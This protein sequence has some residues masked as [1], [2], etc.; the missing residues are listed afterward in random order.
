[1]GE[2]VRERRRVPWILW[3]FWALWRLLTFVLEVTGRLLCGVVGLA[4]LVVGVTMTLSVVG[5]PLG[6]PMALVG[7]LLLLRAV[8]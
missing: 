4:L 1:M 3:P 5:A 6:I 8:F 7:F 2:A